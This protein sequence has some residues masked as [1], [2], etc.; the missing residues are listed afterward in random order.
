MYETFGPT[1]DHQSGQ[2]TFRLFFPDSARDILQYGRGGQPHIA[3]IAIPGTFHAGQWDPALAPRMV[4]EDHPQGLLYS[5]TTQ[6]SAGFY[7]YKFFVRFE[8]GVT[9]W[10]NDPCTRHGCHIAGS[11]NSGFVVGGNLISSNSTR[12]RPTPPLPERQI[13][14]EL[15]IDDFT[16]RLPGDR[17]QRNMLDL[18]HDHLDRITDLGVT[19]VQPMPWTGVPESGFNWGYEPHLFFSVDERLTDLSGVPAG[20]IVNRLFSLRELIDALHER[21]VAIIMDGVFNHVRSE[22]PYLQLYQNRDDCPFVG[23][24]EEGAFFEDLDFANGCTRQF[25][26][27]VCRYWIERFDIDGLRFDYVRGFYRRAGGDPGISTLIASLRHLLRS[28]GRE[29]FSLILENLTDNRYQAIDDANS[30]DATGTW[31]DPLLF[32]A[33]ESGRSG[34]LSA[35][36]LRAL[37][38]NRDC[39]PGKAAITYIENHDHGTLV[40]KIGGNAINVPRDPHGYRTQPHAIALFT[41]PGTVM[42]HNG[43]E[44][45]EEAYLPE[46]GGDRVR[47]RPLRWEHRDDDVGQALGTLYRRLIQIRRHHSG[48]TSSNF[49]PRFVDVHAQIFDAD[50]FGIDV[51]RQLLVF[52][53]WG[54]GLD[55]VMERFIVAVNFSAQPHWLDLTFPFDGSWTDL[56]SGEVVQVRAQRLSGV[57]VPSHYGRLFHARG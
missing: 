12:P 6:L 11:D 38:A 25:I 48:L 42:L 29:N 23:V 22:F 2:V 3:E 32:A 36:Y 16:A 39:L 53:R 37:D 49:H 34:T 19:T 33:F 27:D 9:R 35:S 13:I 31:Y 28:M 18:V 41:A 44:W 15:M 45:G 30:I 47:P 40:N 21:G 17:S 52:H 46:M 26:L 14:Y 43:Q 54:E 51:H 7:A 50:G 8:N 1:V 20:E 24:F 57:S 56:L 10:V 4:L 55:G 5:H